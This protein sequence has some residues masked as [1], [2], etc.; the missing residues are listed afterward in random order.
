METLRIVVV[1]DEAAQRDLLT[2]F[3]QKQGHTVLACPSGSEAL[4]TV[5]DQQVDLVVS[6]CRMPGMSGPELLHHLRAINP[7]LPLILMTAYGTIET[8]VQAMRDGAADYLTKPLDLE[9][10]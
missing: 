5:R 2:G 7:E 10:L 9:E 3:L 6:D 8:A 4:A 1:D